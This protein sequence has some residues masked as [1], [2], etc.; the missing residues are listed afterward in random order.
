M[1]FAN[2]TP[3]PSGELSV[4]RADVFSRVPAP[5]FAGLRGGRR[6]VGRSAHTG[7]LS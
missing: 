4:P 6:A 1:F 2:F 5:P 7:Q 3:D